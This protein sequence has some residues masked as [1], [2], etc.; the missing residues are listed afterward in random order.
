MDRIRR[1][2]GNDAYRSLASVHPK[3]H[4]STS[5]NHE[6]GLVYDEVEVSGS[7]S[8]SNWVYDYRTPQIARVRLRPHEKTG[9][10]TLFHM[11]LVKLGLESQN[12]TVDALQMLPW[13]IGE[14]I[15]QQITQK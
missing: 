10:R 5:Y 9:A 15:W 3:P 2:H 1:S 14:R 6:S 7:S 8:Q 13:S 12:L 4:R 11:A